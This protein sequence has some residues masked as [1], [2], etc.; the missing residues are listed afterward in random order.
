MVIRETSVSF[1]SCTFRKS[2]SSA[3]YLLKEGFFQNFTSNTLIDNDSYPIAI[4]PNYAHT[5]GTGNIYS[6]TTGILVTNDSYLDKTGAYTWMNQNTPYIIEGDLR[7]GSVGEG[8]TLVIAPGN[9]IKCMTTAIITVAYG[10]SYIGTITAIGT[11]TEKIIF[12]AYTAIPFKKDWNGFIINVG[13]RNCQFD[14]CEI[15]HAGST[16]TTTAVIYLNHAGTEFAISSSLIAHSISYGISV[17][18]TTTVDI[19][20]GVTFLDIDKES[21]HIR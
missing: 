5:I 10:T 11:P 13:A 4:T 6:T 1:K 15:T 3:L 16:I 7:I 9:I 8:T 14:Y 20:N 19:T 18:K 12:T 17:D 2:A 21:Y